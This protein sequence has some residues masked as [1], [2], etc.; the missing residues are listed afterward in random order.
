MK[1]PYLYDDVAVMKNKLNI[2]DS[3]RL[4]DAEAA[5]TMS[6]LLKISELFG[7]GEFDID[8]LQSIHKY[9]FGDIYEWAG[10]FRKI[11]IEKS[12]RVLNGLS[13]K[14]SDHKNIKIDANKVIKKL[15]NINWEKLSLEQQAEKLAKL[16][17]ELWRVHCFREGNTRTTIT[18]I[19][20]F[21]KS[22]GIELNKDLFKQHSGYV[23]DSLVLSSIDE[24]SDSEYLISIVKDSIT[25]IQ[26]E[27]LR[28]KIMNIY[29]KT[30]PGIKYI[31][32]NTAK[33]INTLNKDAG[34]NLSIEE[35]KQIF[36]DL[37][38]KL[39]CHYSKEDLQEFKKL[40]DAM[41]DLRKSK[42]LLKQE[43]IHHKVVEQSK[44]KSSELLER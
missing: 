26:G 35:I 33:I 24:Y 40:T 19:E 17:A 42:L 27:G 21:A 18:F 23:R 12:E 5:I 13:V 38:K 4:E 34:K 44:I 3:E 15:N 1:D 31:S 28:R 22:K 7:N 32:E 2:K 36:N 8:K 41:D 39:E 9:I 11:N 6:R 43:E 20:L 30:F 10:E 37:G 25:P 14:Y 16:T 29:K